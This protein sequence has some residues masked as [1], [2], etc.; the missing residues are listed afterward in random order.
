VDEA[1]TH[2]YLRHSTRD[3]DSIV[4]SVIT[5]EKRFLALGVVLREHLSEPRKESKAAWRGSL[6]SDAAGED[7]ELQQ[8]AKQ[9]DEQPRQ[10]I[11][12]DRLRAPATVPL[13]PGP[14]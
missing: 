10:V 2:F 7:V 11:K 5:E 12:R 1:D 6:A 13:E 14:C 8:P 3:E 9:A 4:T